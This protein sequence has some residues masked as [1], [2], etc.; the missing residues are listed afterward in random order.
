[1][2]VAKNICILIIDQPIFDCCSVPCGIP[3]LLMTLTLAKLNELARQW[4]QGLMNFSRWIKLGSG[5][6]SG[7]PFVPNTRDM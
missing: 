3:T 1:M 2:H 5:Y 7:P 6:L 4:G